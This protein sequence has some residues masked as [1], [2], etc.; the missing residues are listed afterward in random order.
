MIF[1]YCGQL[2]CGTRP[3]IQESLRSDLKEMILTWQD[4]GFWHLGSDSLTGNHCP[5]EARQMITDRVLNRVPK[6]RVAKIVGDD[7]IITIDGFKKRIN[8]YDI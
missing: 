8:I 3:D 1:D 4:I 2:Y 7:I 6:D 5:I